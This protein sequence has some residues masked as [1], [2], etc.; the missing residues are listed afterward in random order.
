V[1]G[2]DI[3]I[4]DKHVAHSYLFVM[5]LLG[6]DINLSKS[7]VSKIGVCEFAKKL[8]IKGV[9]FSPLGPRSILEFMK[10]PQAFKE[11]VMN[12]QIFEDM[13]V[14]VFQEQLTKMLSKTPLKGSR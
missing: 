7:L 5:K 11:M 1:L 12:Y 10:S 9:D 2:D 14:A 3:V 4:A 6:V 13:D 8:Y